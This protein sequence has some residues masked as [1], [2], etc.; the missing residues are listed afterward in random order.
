MIVNELI[1]SVSVDSPEKIAQDVFALAEARA[2]DIAAE[3]GGY[4]FNQNAI[5]TEVDK[6]L[7]DVKLRVHKLID[8]N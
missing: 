6:I 1:E 3:E 7:V 4:G 2:A 5:A 8:Q